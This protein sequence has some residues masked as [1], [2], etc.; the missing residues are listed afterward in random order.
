MYTE[1]EFYEQYIAILRL[2][3]TMGVNLESYF[4]NNDTNSYRITVKNQDRQRV[5]TL[6]RQLGIR[7]CM[8]QVQ[9]QALRPIPNQ[10][11]PLLNTNQ[12]SVYKGQG[13]AFIRSSPKRCNYN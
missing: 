8:S 7:Y 4:L 3:G 10:L 13:G 5:I 1:F 9:F 11:A 2:L 12:A 6:M